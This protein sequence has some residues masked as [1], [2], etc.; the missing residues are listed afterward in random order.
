MR[1]IAGTNN[2]I[3][4]VLD[5]PGSTL[6]VPCRPDSH[7]ISRLRTMFAKNRLADLPHPKSL[8]DGQRLRDLQCRCLGNICAEFWAKL[9]HIVREKRGLVT[10]A[11][12]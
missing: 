6:P 5:V 9:G 10:G 1:R 11:R 3:G 12:N 4:S 2:T 7:C 8:S